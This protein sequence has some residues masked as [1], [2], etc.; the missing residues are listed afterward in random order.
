MAGW[1]NRKGGPWG[2][3]VSWR[4]G[5]SQGDPGASTF[6]DGVEEEEEEEGPEK[7]PGGDR[8]WRGGQR[9]RRVRHKVL[10]EEGGS[11]RRGWAAVKN[12]PK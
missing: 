1:M 9:A 8:Y 5:T 7:D 10:K 6:K 2:R 3:K 4:E 11:R 12:T